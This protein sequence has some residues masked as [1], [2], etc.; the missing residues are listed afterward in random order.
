MPWAMALRVVSLPAT[1]S[2]STKK[3][4]SSCGQVLAVDLGAD[5]LGDDVVA[6]AGR[7]GPERNG[8]TSSSIKPRW[9]KFSGFLAPQ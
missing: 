3:P 7:A 4:N 6:G 2:I 9:P 8:N 1:A 5:E